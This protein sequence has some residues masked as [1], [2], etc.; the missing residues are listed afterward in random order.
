MKHRASSPYIVRGTSTVIVVANA[1]AASG[2][3]SVNGQV[4]STPNVNN[5]VAGPNAAGATIGVPSHLG[6]SL[7]VA[8][9]SVVGGTLL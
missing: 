4:T 6:L 8:I 1:P 9:L 2:V 7:L 5:A 3:A